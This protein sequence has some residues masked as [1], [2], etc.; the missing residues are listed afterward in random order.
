MRQRL[1][2]KVSVIMPRLDFADDAIDR[3]AAITDAMAGPTLSRS[4][5][6][7]ERCSIERTLGVGHEIIL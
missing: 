1:R 5:C 2:R 6:I 4:F 7:Q 3:M